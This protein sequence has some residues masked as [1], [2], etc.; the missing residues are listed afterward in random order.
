MGAEEQ[1]YAGEYD[2]TVYELHGAVTEADCWKMLERFRSEGRRID[3]VDTV[4]TNNRGAALRYQCVFD[5][6]DTNPVDP[7]FEDRRYNTA[8]EYAP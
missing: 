5:G 1:T 6:Q 7:P 3:L 2:P 4:R 8:D